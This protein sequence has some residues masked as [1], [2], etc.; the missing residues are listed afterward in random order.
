MFFICS[1]TTITRGGVTQKTEDAILNSWPDCGQ[2]QP[3]SKSADSDLMKVKPGDAQLSSASQLGNKQNILCLIVRHL[4][5]HCVVWPDKMLPDFAQKS[6]F[7]KWQ[8]VILLC[9]TKV[10]GEELPCPL[11]YHKQ[12]TATGQQ[13]RETKYHVR[14]NNHNAPCTRTVI[15]YLQAICTTRNLLV[16]KQ[17]RSTQLDW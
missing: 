15:A 9:M 6:G 17:L 11:S 16:K 10:H 4:L 12:Q 13:E 7:S 5:D 14:C 8:V 1:A 2:P 3:L